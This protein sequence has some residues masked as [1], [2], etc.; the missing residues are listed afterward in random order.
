[1]GWQCADKKLIRKDPAEAKDPGGISSFDPRKMETLQD[2]E[3]YH[4]I[5]NIRKI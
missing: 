4:G 1:M 2:T 5:T 3:M